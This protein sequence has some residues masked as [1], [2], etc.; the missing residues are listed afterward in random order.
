MA[1]VLLASGEEAD[2]PSTCKC[3]TLGTSGILAK[4]SSLDPSQNFGIEVT[5]LD[6][7]NIPKSTGLQLTDRIFANA[8][9]KRVSSIQIVNSALKT[10]NVNAF[11]GLHNLY[12]LNLTANHLNLL[13]PDMFANN[14]HLE[15]LSLSQNPLQYMQADPSPYKGYFLN[16]PSLQE[17][18][19]SS[20]GLPHLLPTMFTKLTTLIYINLANNQIS[21]IPSETFARLID[22]EE[23]DLSNNKITSLT[24]EVFQFNTELTE[25]NLKNNPLSS[26]SGISIPNLLKLDISQCAFKN[27]DAESFAGFT[28]LKNLNLSGNTL[29]TI[30][31]DTFKMLK[32]LLYLDLSNNNLIGQIPEDVFMYNIELET[33][34]LKNNPGMKALPENGFEGKFS[35]LYLMDVS[36][37]GLTQLSEDAFKGMNHISFLNLSSNE[38]QFIKPGTLAQKIVHLDLSYNKITNFDQVSFVPNSWVRKLYLSG[39]PIKKLSPNNFINISRLTKLYL[40]SCDLRQLWDLGDGNQ[41]SLNSLVYLNVANNKI[42]S[43]TVEDLSYIDRAQTVILTNN[44]LICDDDLRKAL[45]HLIKNGVASSDS[46]ERKQSEEIRYRKLNDNVEVNADKDQLGWNSFMNN[47]CHEENQKI[48][49]EPTYDTY[50]DPLTGEDEET[51]EISYSGEPNIDTWGTDTWDFAEVISNGPEDEIPKE[52]IYPRSNYMW[53]IIIVA[54]SAFTI[55]LGLVVLAA[56]FLRWKRQKNS[57]RNKIIKR[58]SLCNTP[59]LRRSASTVYQQ[60][61]EDA[62]APTTPVMS[63]KQATTTYNF[64]EK[65]SHDVNNST[66]THQTTRAS[67]KSSPFHHSNIVPESV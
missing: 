48:V 57:Y 60:L 62:N 44:P 22:L 63:T 2:C 42:T 15:K 32:K 27:V 24:P 19:L 38:I 35:E 56:F 67:Y 37:C 51:T 1:T 17:I 18:D 12:N 8:G 21:E 43:L 41:T 50:Y 36:N 52:L 31:S 33:L 10:I 49:V 39:N 28:H 3:E 6:L 4:C 45:K 66:I 5:A 9:L 53:P 26:V 55:I 20:C 7:S 29:T 59:R 25:L 11:H 58:P 13:E 16:V 30:P 65:S 14:T 61:Y 54:L 23:V 40:K 34:K 46:A 47:V 64:P